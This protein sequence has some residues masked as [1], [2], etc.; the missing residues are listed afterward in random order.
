MQGMPVLS[1]ARQMGSSSGLGVVTTGTPLLA[2]P[3]CPKPATPPTSPKALPSTSGPSDLGVARSC[4][5]TR[6]PCSA[7]VPLSSLAAWNDLANLGPSCW[8]TT[9]RLGTPPSA[10]FRKMAGKASLSCFNTSCAPAK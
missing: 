2:V 7:A 3:S 10:I 5:S 1:A 9:T 8:D 4:R 6:R